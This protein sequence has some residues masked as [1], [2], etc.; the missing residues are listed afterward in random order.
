MKTHSYLSPIAF[1]LALA[2]CLIVSPAL[3]NDCDAPPGERGALPSNLILSGDSKRIL[4]KVWKR[5]ATFRD[6]CRRIAGSPW[7]KIKVRFVAKRA[8]DYEALTTLTRYESG[9]TVSTIQ[10]F[11]TS[12]YVERI[13]HEFEHIIE[14]IEGMNLQSLAAK[15]GA[16]VRS[17]KPG[18]YETERAIRAG[19]RV[20]EE[21][22]RAKSGCRD[23][24]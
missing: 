22:R 7:M 18:Y 17:V 1:V 13:G 6:Q 15:E 12:G 9:F 5:S 21:Y 2:C 3:A 4:E 8:E 10:I 19:R 24:G 14:Q 11:I 20:H 23:W 16:G